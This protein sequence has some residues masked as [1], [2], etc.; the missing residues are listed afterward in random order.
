MSALCLLWSEQRHALKDWP[1]RPL[2]LFLEQGDGI[3]EW[4][5]KFRFVDDQGS[6]FTCRG[7]KW[8]WWSLESDDDLQPS[9]P[10]GDL[11]DVRGDYQWDC[12]VVDNCK[13]CESN[14]KG[15]LY[16]LDSDVRVSLVSHNLLR[17]G[18]RMARITLPA[19]RGMRLKTP[20]NDAEKKERRNED[21][22]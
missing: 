13:S 16:E 10:S 18:K 12:I 14:K 11:A 15:F 5:S 21:D 4:L 8:F 3:R 17:V 2:S 20:G 6:S 7:E 9:G 22:G 1:L 19:G